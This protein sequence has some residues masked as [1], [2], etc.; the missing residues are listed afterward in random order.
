MVD[1]ASLTGMMHSD[2]VDNVRFEGRV[3]DSSTR[4]PASKDPIL[5][6]SIIANKLVAQGRRR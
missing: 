6:V 2:C 1:K 3:A 4:M 5:K